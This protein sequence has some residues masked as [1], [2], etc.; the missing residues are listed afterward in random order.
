[1]I[2]DAAEA[3]GSEYQGRKAGGFGL[4]SAFSFHGSKTLTTGEG[5]M[6]VTDSKEVDERCRSLANHG[7]PVGDRMFETSAVAYKYKMSSLQA[8]LGLAQLE[9]IDELV[10]RKREIFDW[11]RDALAGLDGIG[12][13]QEPD[14]TLNTYWMVTA[15]VDARFGVSTHDLVEALWQA[16]I[17]AR[18]FFAPLSSL[19]AYAGSRASR[20]A[21]RRNPIA[22]DIAARAVAL[23]SGFNLTR[24]LV[25]DVGEQLRSALSR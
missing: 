15:V 21:E 4:A 5:G 7:R 11:Y 25:M 9:R 6:L 20:G 19:E 24:E 8:A 1:V 18:P 12:L 22:Y 23:P 16:G 14:G 3:I 13:N 10:S 17:D 2:E